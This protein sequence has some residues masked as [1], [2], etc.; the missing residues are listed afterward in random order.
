MRGS[1]SSG[2]SQPSGSATSGLFGAVTVSNDRSSSGTALEMTCMWEFSGASC[3][4]AAMGTPKPKRVSDSQRQMHSTTLF[5]NVVGTCTILTWKSARPLNS[6]DRVMDETASTVYSGLPSTSTLVTFRR[7]REHAIRSLNSGW[8]VPSCRRHQC[9]HSY[10]PALPHSKP[11]DDRNP[12]TSNR[13][14]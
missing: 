12:Q 6:C 7:I 10:R 2:C 11:S 13:A 9:C 1:T 5:T 14:Y 8:D 4:A 3:C